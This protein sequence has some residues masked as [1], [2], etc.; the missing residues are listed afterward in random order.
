M[1]GVWGAHRFIRSKHAH[2]RPCSFAYVHTLR[3]APR[4]ETIA[5]FHQFLSDG[6]A[7]WKTDKSRP[8]FAPRESEA[9]TITLLHFVIL[10]AGVVTVHLLHD[11]HDAQTSWF[12]A[13]CTG[14]QGFDAFPS[15]PPQHTRSGATLLRYA[16]VT[17]C[18]EFKGAN[19]KNGEREEERW[20]GRTHSWG[21]AALSK[22]RGACRRTF[23]TDSLGPD[24]QWVVSTSL[25]V[26]TSL[27]RTT[28]QG[29]TST[30][31]ET[32]PTVQSAAWMSDIVQKKK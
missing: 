18:Q 25:L 24:K 8:C 26:H 20:V 29:Q 16:N 2:E 12:G 32:Q 3:E 17:T 6:M 27:W 15:D 31:A 21:P 19:R 1:R 7:H 28:A 9:R 30:S 11:I 10:R 22:L 14:S 23:D 13:G 5:F 4:K